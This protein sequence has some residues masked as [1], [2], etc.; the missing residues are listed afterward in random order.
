MIGK[1]VLDVQ[2]VT[3]VERFTWPDKQARFDRAR[4]AMPAANAIIAWA[5][6]VCSVDEISAAVD[7]YTTLDKYAW[8]RTDSGTTEVQ[9]FMY[10]VLVHP[11][12]TATLMNDMLLC[13]SE[14]Q[15]LPRYM[16]TLTT[17]RPAP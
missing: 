8:R 2:Q 4:A 16:I 5:P 10:T 13:L 7:V 11:D 12:T 1:H 3:R 15:K 17:Q 9:V 14:D 6:V